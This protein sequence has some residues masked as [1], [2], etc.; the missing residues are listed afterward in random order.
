[1]TTYLSQCI[2]AALQAGVE[3]LEVYRSSDLEVEFKSDQ[4][5]LTEADKRSH[6]KILELLSHTNIPFLSEEGDQITYEERRIWERFWLIDPL[7][8][9]KEFIK[10]NGEFTVNIAL[11]EDG[12][13]ILGVVYVPVKNTLYFGSSETGSYKL[14]LGEHESLPEDIQQWINK[15]QKLTE[16][17]QERHYTI[18]ASRSHL[19]PETEQFIDE[20]K[21]LHG[22]INI[23]SAGSSLKLC[24]VAEGSAN[25]Y[26]RLAPTME[27]DTAAGHAV[28]KFAG[29]KVHDFKTGD[30]LR[31]NKEDLHNPWFV[32]ERLEQVPVGQE[33]N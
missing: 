10:R 18:V 14:I 24:L 6:N 27:W 7:D 26:P 13:P 20:K 19:S 11:I 23:I 12:I 30:E 3:I 17:K 1:M 8:G 15:A 16:A 28:A 21:K 31:Y 32:V 29:C 33:D 4:S 5:P 25:V 9:T 2:R 22:E